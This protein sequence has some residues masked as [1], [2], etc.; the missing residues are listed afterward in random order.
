MVN[1]C[2]PIIINYPGGWSSS[3]PCNNCNLSFL[4]YPFNAALIGV[5]PTGAIPTSTITDPI[6][7]LS[8][9]KIGF[10]VKMKRGRRTQRGLKKRLVQMVGKDAQ[11]FADERNGYLSFYLKK[12]ITNNGCH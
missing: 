8:C 11:R 5:W 3:I 7:T 12:I 4:N 2:T 6:S 9:P 10:H 1:T